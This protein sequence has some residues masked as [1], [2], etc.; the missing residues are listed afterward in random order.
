MIIETERCII[1]DLCMD[2]ADALYEVLSDDEVMTYIEPAFDLEQTRE[3]IK[4]AG[5]CEPPLVYALEWKDGRKVI[6]HVIYHQYE[7]DS[8]ELGWIINRNYWG[9]GIADEVT[10][11]LVETA[12]RN[13]VRSCVIECDNEQAASRHI[14]LKNGFLYEGEDDGCEVYR[15]NLR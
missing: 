10:K 6:G 15:L 9:R 2:D 3:F 5:L 13:G 14:A 4:E 12:G 8:Y 1:R 11:A 7:E